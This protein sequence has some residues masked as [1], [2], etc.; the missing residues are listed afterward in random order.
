MYAYKSHLKTLREINNGI[1]CHQIFVY[2][3]CVYYIFLIFSSLNFRLTLDWL[4]LTDSTARHVLEQK[5]ARSKLS[6]NDTCLFIFLSKERINLGC[7]QV[8]A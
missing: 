7:I 3:Y 2:M 8:V 6:G 1:Y 5:G 4:N